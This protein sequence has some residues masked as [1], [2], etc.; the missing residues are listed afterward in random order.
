MLSTL[1]HSAQSLKSL[2]GLHRA[3]A[4]TSA[5][6]LFSALKEITPKVGCPLSP[7]A[8]QPL[9]PLSALTIPSRSKPSSRP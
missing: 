6:D 3:L 9:L 7:R 8:Q 2:R 5:P 4:T 1:K